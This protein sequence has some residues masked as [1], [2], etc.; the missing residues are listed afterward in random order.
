MH[1]CCAAEHRSSCSRWQT[2]RTNRRHCTGCGS[3]KTPYVHA[4]L[5]AFDEAIIV[6][7]CDS[8][9]FSGTHSSKLST[10]G[11]CPKIR[12]PAAC[13]SRDRQQDTEPVHLENADLSKCD[14]KSPVD[15]LLSGAMEQRERLIV[16][17]GCFLHGLPRCSHF[18][19]QSLRCCCAGSI[20]GP[21]A[22]W[23][24]S[25]SAHDL[26]EF[27][28]GRGLIECSF[29][30]QWLPEDEEVHRRENASLAAGHEAPCHVN[31]HVV[32]VLHRASHCLIRS[33]AAASLAEGE[34]PGSL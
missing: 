30:R 28:H 24:A 19:I 11:T 8:S 15:S 27:A 9:T 21:S 17:T 10:P 7:D 3:C 33:P 2:A 25:W 32:D 12:T 22:T 5:N 13:A 16:M 20:E 14:E 29:I 6:V 4:L 31:E 34:E 18:H 26:C 23:A 1:A